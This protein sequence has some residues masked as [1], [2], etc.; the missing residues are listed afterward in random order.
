MPENIY[1]ERFYWNTPI[2]DP[3][4]I[5]DLYKHDP[6]AEAEVQFLEEPDSFQKEI[7]VLFDST[8]N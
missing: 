1:F 8:F 7:F 4:P 5:A 3:E 6:S 2:V